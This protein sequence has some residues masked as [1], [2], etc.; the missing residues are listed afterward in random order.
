MSAEPSG[1]DPFVR[2]ALDADVQAVAEDM[3]PE[4]AA[5]ALALG[6]DPVAALKAS[7]A[8]STHVAAI[9]LNGRAIGVFGVGPVKL[10][11]LDAGCIWMIGTPKIETISYHF[12]R[13]S[14]KWVDAMHTVHPVLWNRVYAKNEVH[15]RWLKWLGFRII[16]L[17][18]QGP[19]NEPFYQFIRM[20]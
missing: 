19:N 12:L 18:G 16:G 20:K 14:S 10:G 3:R 9:D 5:E 13:Q 6:L 4:D 17:S 2:P 8:A 11:E 1:S 7:V 15:I